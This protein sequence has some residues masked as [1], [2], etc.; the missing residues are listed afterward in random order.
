MET[1]GVDVWLEGLQSLYLPGQHPDHLMSECRG[2]AE[3]TGLIQGELGQ[4]ASVSPT[5]HFSTGY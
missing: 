5:M 4:M 2:R 1:F 3:G